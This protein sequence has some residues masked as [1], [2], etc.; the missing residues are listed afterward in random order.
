MLSSGVSSETHIEPDPEIVRGVWHGFLE[1]PPRIR[2]AVKCLVR[3]G[4]GAVLVV[5]YRDSVK[6]ED[7]FAPPGGGVRFGET[8]ETALAREMREEFAT[9]LVN[10]RRV[11]MLENFFTCEGVRGH[12]L[13]MVFAAELSRREVYRQ[14]T[15]AVA[16][17][18]SRWTAHW[19]QKRDLRSED[20]PEA[21]PLYPDGFS[22]LAFVPDE[23]PE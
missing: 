23:S 15:I 11:G 21:L 19:L 3:R 20:R 16:D 13:V 2:V 4:D 17:G 8:L 1:D 22:R 9:E 10:V 18:G 6:G 14:E 5:R 12:E 7:F